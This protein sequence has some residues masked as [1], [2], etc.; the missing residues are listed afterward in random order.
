MK[1]ARVLG[2]DA[3]GMSTVPEAMVANR[4][5]MEVCGISMISNMAAGIIDSPLSHEEVLEAAKLS[6][7]NFRQLF[8]SFIRSLK[9]ARI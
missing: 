9:N 3:V 5:G 8:L 4:L 6:E 2:A 7:Q 1:A